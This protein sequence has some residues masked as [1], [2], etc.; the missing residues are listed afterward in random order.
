V[1][2]VV[3]LVVFMRGLLKLARIYISVPEFVHLFLPPIVLIAVVSGLVA[4][5]ISEG[6]V[7]A[8]F[9]HAMIMAAITLV[10]VWISGTMSIQLITMPTYG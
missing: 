1:I 10:A 9:K 3:V 4:G 5:K 8:G 6:T 2:V 7:A